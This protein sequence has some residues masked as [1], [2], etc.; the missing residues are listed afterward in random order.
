LTII[1]PLLGC[2]TPLKV[3]AMPSEILADFLKLTAFAEEIKKHPRTVRRWCDEWGLPYTKNGD[4]ILIHIP[5]YR[6]WLMG[7]MSNQKKNKR[8]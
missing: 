5:T 6:D 1:F 4:E 2:S 7:R 3:Q 8:A